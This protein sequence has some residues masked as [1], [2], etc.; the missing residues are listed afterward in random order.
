M[1]NWENTLP[2]QLSHLLYYTGDME[3]GLNTK[4]VSTMHLP[5]YDGLETGY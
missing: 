3:E 2:S 5:H 4:W 1:C